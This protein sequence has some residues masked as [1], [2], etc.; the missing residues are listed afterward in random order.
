MKKLNTLNEEINR[1]K[2]LFGESRLYGNLVTEDTEPSPDKVKEVIDSEEEIETNVITTNLDDE[3]SSEYC[4]P[5]VDNRCRVVTTLEDSMVDGVLD[6][7]KLFGF[8]NEYDQ[9]CG[10]PKIEIPKELLSSITNI[11]RMEYPSMFESDNGSIEFCNKTFSNVTKI[12]VLEIDD[13]D[14]IKNKFP[15][16]KTIDLL[17]VNKKGKILNKLPD[18]VLINDFY[19]GEENFKIVDDFI[20]INK[21]MKKIPLENLSDYYFGY[22]VDE[23]GWEEKKIGGDYYI[24][25]PNILKGKSDDSVVTPKT[26]PKTTPSTPKE[27][28]TTPTTKI[29]PVLNSNVENEDVTWSDEDGTYK[30]GELKYLGIKNGLNTFKIETE[31]RR[32]IGDDWQNKI[33]EMYKENILSSLKKMKDKYGLNYDPYGNIDVISKNKFT[34]K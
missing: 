27:P 10:T 18:D 31:G 3:G 13:Y 19:F 24:V 23:M 4:P 29:E 14:K 9:K 28:T 33:S 15:N 21:Q 26:E 2:S 5:V 34:I 20:K 32:V 16:L 22:L 17:I 6:I 25:N 7:Y 1:M 8:E 12:G 11:K 30:V